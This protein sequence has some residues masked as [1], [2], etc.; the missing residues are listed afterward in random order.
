MIVVT[1]TEDIYTAN[2]D[3]MYSAAPS[4]YQ[5]CNLSRINGHA[6]ADSYGGFEETIKCFTSSNSV[7]FERRSAEFII[8]YDESV[9]HPDHPDPAYLNSKV[10]DMHTL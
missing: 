7:S 1:V 10:S 4:D 8:R 3:I 9:D 5:S 6:D 2:M